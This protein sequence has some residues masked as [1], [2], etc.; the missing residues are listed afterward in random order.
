MQTVDAPP[1][2]C[3]HGHVMDEHNAMWRTDKRLVKGGY[4]Q[5]ITCKRESGRKGM[6]R[7]R[8]GEKPKLVRRPK[9]QRWRGPKQ[10][11]AAAADQIFRH[12]VALDDAISTYAP[13]IAEAR[14]RYTEP[15]AKFRAS[16]RAEHHERASREIVEAVDRMAKDESKKP[17]KYL[18][19]K[20]EAEK[21]WD[22]F[23]AALEEARNTGKNL[24][25][26]EDNPGP[27]MDYDDDNP[28]TPEEAYELCYGCPLLELCSVYAELDRPAHG[29]WGGD[30]WEF[31]EPKG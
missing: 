29:I 10:L 21:A 2:T 27:Y 6:R 9:N 22:R 18:Q 25:N 28:P 13:L 8:S 12:G 11:V 23:S 17:W 16:V 30:V 19:V 20:P 4:W 1:L 5:C 3:I 26:C 14:L 31:G 24:P 15:S 7:I